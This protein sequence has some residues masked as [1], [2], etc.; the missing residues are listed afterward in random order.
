[1]YR[2][3]GPS[4]LRHSFG[5]ENSDDESESEQQ[6][7]QDT[8]LQQQEQQRRNSTPIPKTSFFDSRHRSPHNI[9]VP[10][11][12]PG[13]TVSAPYLSIRIIATSGV[14]QQQADINKAV[15]ISEYNK[16]IKTRKPSDSSHSG[17]SFGSNSGSSSAS[18]LTLRN[19]KCAGISENESPHSVIMRERHSLNISDVKLASTVA[20]VDTHVFPRSY[21]VPQVHSKLVN[22]RL[23]SQMQAFVATASDSKIAVSVQDKPGRKIGKW[24]RTHV[25]SL[26]REKRE[27]NVEELIEFEPRE[28]KK[29]FH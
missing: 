26:F 20:A 16:L 6:S 18:T 8:S 7:Y 5:T 3:T 1:M 14:E 13:D 9:A 28:R 10:A 12:L 24:W 4:S 2:G 23:A 29:W 17:F 22:T 21:S 19:E 27:I 11:T 25:T 15:L